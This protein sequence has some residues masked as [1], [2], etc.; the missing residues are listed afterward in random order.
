MPSAAG[1][2]LTE[3][4]LLCPDY[5][6]DTCIGCAASQTMW[7]LEQ[8]VESCIECQ[9]SPSQMQ[10][11]FTPHRVLSTFSKADGAPGQKAYRGHCSCHQQFATFCFHMLDLSLTQSVPTAYRHA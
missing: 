9:S 2:V 6:G 10:V 4:I 11:G 8:P 3:D 7:S 1:N 5:N